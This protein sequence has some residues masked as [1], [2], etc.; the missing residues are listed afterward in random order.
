VTHVERP[1]PRGGLACSIARAKWSPTY[2][3]RTWT[4]ARDVDGRRH[5]RRKEVALGRLR[6]VSLILILGAWGGATIAAG[7]DDAAS[8]ASKANRQPPPV[9]PI[10]YLEAGARLWNSAQ[11]S[12][13]YAKAAQYLD[14]ANRYRDML[15]P[16]EQATLDEYLKELAKS[17]AAPSSAPAAVAPAAEPAKAAAVRPR[18]SGPTASPGAPSN[19]AGPAGP[20]QIAPSI[21]TK[22]RGRWLLHEAREQI[23]V[24]NYDLAQR[25]V[26]EAEALDI[27]WGLFDDTPAKVT[28]E[29]KKTRPKTVASKSAADGKPHDRR[30]A[31]IKL[32]EARTALNSRQFEQAESIAMEL[33]GWGL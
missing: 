29:I 20:D 14:A 27:K 5:E 15:Q 1:I 4:V 18:W 9:P 6:T 32:R 25:K 10:K 21:D 3:D 13:D 8:A 12:K 30:A 19:G 33:K 2:D 28:E 24:G 26:D 23:H 17:K 22:Q 31:R 7:P 16:D 11:D